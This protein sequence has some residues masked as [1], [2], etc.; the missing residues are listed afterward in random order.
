MKNSLYGFSIQNEIEALLMFQLEWVELVFFSTKNTKP[1]SV[2]GF[3]QIKIHTKNCKMYLN[4][5]LFEFVRA[6]KR[7]CFCAFP[8]A[9]NTTERVQT[10]TLPFA[11]K[12]RALC[13]KTIQN[14]LIKAIFPRFVE[15][16]LQQLH[17]L[18]RVW[19]CYLI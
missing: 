3:Y 5:W 19:N 14:S 10:K 16:L 12:N 15:I 6:S 1:N 9:G 4:I 18:H 13:I 2:F 17:M 8:S 11:F 7:V